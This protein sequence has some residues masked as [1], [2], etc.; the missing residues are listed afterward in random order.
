MTPPTPKSSLTW[1]I[2]CVF[3]AGYCFT[4]PNVAIAFVPVMETFP[5]MMSSRVR[6]YGLVNAAK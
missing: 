2:P 1:E 5:E 3:N 4:S 6:I